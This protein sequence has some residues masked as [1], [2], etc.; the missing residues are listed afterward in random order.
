VPGK[1]L[2]SVGPDEVPKPQPKK[3]KKSMV[4]A[5]ADGDEVALL[6]AMRDRLVVALNSSATPAHTLA[7]LARQVAQLNENIDR[8]V[9]R[10]AADNEAPMAGDE[11]WDPSA[12]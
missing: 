12:I 6:E 9:R 1:R 8:L 11:P 4:Q 7:P 2:R 3:A 10:I 5:A